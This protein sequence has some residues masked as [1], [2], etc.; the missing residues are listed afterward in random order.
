MTD[1]EAIEREYRAGQLSIRE[2]ARQHG[3]SAPA[4]LKR[5]KV[6]GWTRNMA[7][8][9]RNAVEAE[10]VSTSVSSANPREPT[11]LKEA[12]ARGVE[13]VIQHREMLSRLRGIFNETSR[14]LH[15][16]LH[17]PS[18]TAAIFQ[19]KGDGVASLLTALSNSAQRII[20]LERQAF[21][22]DPR[23]GEQ[24]QADEY[25][26][27]SDRELDARLKRIIESAQSAE[28]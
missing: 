11:D 14:Q 6:N 27:M 10:L 2:I 8:A 26:R 17:E 12:A 13:V 28:N 3:V 15:Q 20:P 19:A 21:N 5:A 22:L 16:H 25:T 4:I 18:E 23:P 1:W 24:G 9:V 7:Q